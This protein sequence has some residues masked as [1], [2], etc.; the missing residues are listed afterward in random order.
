MCTARAHVPMCML[1][2]C[3][4]TLFF[5]TDDLLDDMLTFY[6]ASLGGNLYAYLPL[7]PILVA[8]RRR[9][10][11]RDRHLFFSGSDFHNTRRLSLTERERERERYPSPTTQQTCCGGVCYSSERAH[12]HTHIRPGTEEDAA[13]ALCLPSIHPPSPLLRTTRRNYM[14]R[15]STLPHPRTAWRG[16]ACRTQWSRCAWG[17]ETK[18]RDEEK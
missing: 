18:W 13:Q 16:G 11:E 10:D 17:D 6:N 8:F 12:T 14:A 9:L 4:H 3:G 1:L 5:A 7:S 15:P 2:R